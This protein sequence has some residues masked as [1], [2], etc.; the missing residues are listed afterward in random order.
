MGF[1]TK[2]EERKNTQHGHIERR[3]GNTDQKINNMYRSFEGV[4]H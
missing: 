3:G 1:S 2:E 4:I